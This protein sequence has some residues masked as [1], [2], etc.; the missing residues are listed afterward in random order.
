MVHST[1]YIPTLRERKRDKKYLDK[2][3]QKKQKV[4]DISF[5]EAI[6]TYGRNDRN[7]PIELHNWHREYA[8]CISN[9]NVHETLVSGCCQVG[10][11][12]IN[13]LLHIYLVIEKQYNSLWVYS[14]E[15]VMNRMV[16]IQFKPMIKYWLEASDRTNTERDNSKNNYLYQYGSANAIF[17]YASTSANVKSNTAAGKAMVS[18][19]AD[20]AFCE[21]RSQ[22]A[23]GSD[24][25]VSRRL[26]AS[27]IDVKPIRQLGTPG[28]V[29]TGITEA[30]DDC[31]YW[32]EPHCMCYECDCEIRLNPYGTL[33][34]Q[35][36]RYK[37]NGEQVRSYLDARGRPHTW[38]H[39]DK[40]NTIKS[41]YFGC[42]NCESEIPKNVRVKESYFK[43]VKTG[44]TLVNFLD[45]CNSSE[46]DIS[47]RIKIFI[48]LSPLL[49]DTLYNLAA[50]IIYEGL[51]TTDAEDWCQQQLGLPSQTEV[52]KVTIDMINR[53]IDA[54]LPQFNY[55]YWVVEQWQERSLSW[56]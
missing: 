11:T 45:Y 49:K 28:R 21:E 12:L 27:R 34:K 1:D 47:D 24:A 53:A 22:W 55:P 20:I 10:K 25:P 37:P 6:E 31:D 32:F 40:A 4:K 14:Q 23:A 42:P 48:Y 8:L 54:P 15:R 18:F 39:D 30:G 56:Y 13:N 17:S 9:L 36:V 52:T 3:Q 38:H 29:G 35:I 43:C 44:I 2:L 33:L 50:N 19:S 26:D 5:I 46:Y 51:N 41:A 16:A 7:Q